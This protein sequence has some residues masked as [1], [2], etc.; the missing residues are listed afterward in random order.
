[1]WRVDTSLVDTWLDG[2]DD[3]TADQVLAAL[4]VLERLGP[5]LGRPLV[6][7]VSQSRHRNMKELRPGSAGRSEIR[8]LFAF[9]PTR[10]AIVLVAGDK[11]GDWK[12][13]YQKNIP[14]ADERFE[15]HLQTLKEGL[16]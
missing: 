1:M 7:T 2:L 14:I 9:D 6:D 16:R 5:S 8:L 13:W 10:K 12:R 15:H 4:R 11:A 3:D